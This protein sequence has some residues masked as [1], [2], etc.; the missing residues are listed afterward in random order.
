MCSMITPAMISFDMAAIQ[1]QASIIFGV[2]ITLIQI[3][4]IRS[5]DASF[6]KMLLCFTHR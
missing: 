4:C 1:M 6:V 5:H 2:L 3:H